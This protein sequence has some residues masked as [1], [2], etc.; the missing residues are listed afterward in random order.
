[1]LKADH[2]HK[3]NW[4]E[5]PGNHAA[6]NPCPHCNCDSSA[7]TMSWTTVPPFNSWRSFKTHAEW[8]A[9][10]KEVVVQGVKG[11]TPM[12]WRHGHKKGWGC[13][14]PCCTKTL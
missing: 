7:T 10:C 11:K 13:R 9:W 12:L 2:E 5:T 1:M 6:F 8:E 3:V 14:S 4:L